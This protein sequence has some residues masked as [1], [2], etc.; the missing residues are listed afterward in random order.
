MTEFIPGRRKNIGTCVPR[1][2]RNTPFLP[3][4]SDKEA[5]EILPKPLNNDATNTNVPALTAVRPTWLCDIGE[6][7]LIKAIPAVTLMNKI[8]Q[9]K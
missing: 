1:I 9:S 2:R 8:N 4:L 5:Q 6:R 3:I 7:L